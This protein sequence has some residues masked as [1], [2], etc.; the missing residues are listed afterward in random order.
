MRVALCCCKPTMVVAGLVRTTQWGGFASRVH[1][2]TETLGRSGIA[3]GPCPIFPSAGR[4][5]FMA[6]RLSSI[7]IWGLCMLEFWPAEAPGGG[8]LWLWFIPTPVHVP[9]ISFSLVDDLVEPIIYIHACLFLWRLISFGCIVCLRCIV[10]NLFSSSLFKLLFFNVTSAP[11]LPDVQLM[12]CQFH[13]IA[14]TLLC[15]NFPF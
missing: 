8:V 7:C 12:R 3:T 6:T 5:S 15:V 11:A 4:A 14:T 13:L 10:S 2:C 9:N 1:S